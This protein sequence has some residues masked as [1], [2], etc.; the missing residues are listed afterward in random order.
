MANPLEYKLRDYQDA[1]G[2]FRRAQKSYNKRIDDYNK[3]LAFDKQGRTIVQD[4]FSGKFYGV[5]ETGRIEQTVLPEGT[6]AEDFNYSSL[7][8]SNK[9][10]LVRRGEPLE[11]KQVREAD[12]NKN[13][14]SSSNVFIE[15]TESIYP[16]KPDAFAMEEPK[17]VKGT[18]G[19]LKRLQG[20][21]ALAL[22]RGIITDVIQSKGT[23]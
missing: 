2:K 18:V 19:Q 3:T 21:D 10:V 15:R 5:D 17:F 4:K 16:D 11:Q 22:E 23:R 20:P 13:P 14:Y 7:P 6:T 9:F 1:L 12:P 8:D